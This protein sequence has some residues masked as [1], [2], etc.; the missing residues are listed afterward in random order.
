[1]KTRLTTAITLALA[2]APVMAQPAPTPAAATAAKESWTRA[3]ATEALAALDEALGSYVF[4]E[5]AEEARRVLRSNRSQYL[6][7]ADREALA[8]RLTKDIGAALNDKHFYVRVAAP[9]PGGGRVDPMAGEAQQGYGIE[10]VRRLPGNIGYIDLRQFGG[11]EE[12]ARRIEAAMDLLA[13]TD[14]LIIDLRNNRGGSGVAMAALIGR[15]ESK[16]I[17]R[18]ALLWR[19]S[20]G[21]FERVEGETTEYPANKRYGRP[22]YLLTAN[23]TISAAEGFAYDLQAAGRVTVVGEPTR[24]GANPMNRPPFDL[25][26]GLIAWVSNGRSEHPVTKGTPNGTGVIPDVRAAPAEALSVAYARALEGVT[27]AEPES[28]FG[29]ELAAAKADPNATLAKAFGLAPG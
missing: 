25:G 22:V 21:S 8:E 9:R 7:I 14:A 10:A 4:P 19:Q 2:A 5:K 20:D 13:D 27:T 28:R 16:P 3:Q 18:S 6:A 26:Q 24:G 23:F 12:S 11:S 15:L 1:M 29:R 17:P